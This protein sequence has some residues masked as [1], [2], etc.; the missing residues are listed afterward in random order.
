M[1]AFSE[2]AGP[3]LSVGAAELRALES[4][5]RLQL[6]AASGLPAERR[7]RLHNRLG[8]LLYGQVR[9][10]EA[11]AEY[12]AALRAWPTL[13]AAAHNRAIVRYRMGECVRYFELVSVLQFWGGF[14][15]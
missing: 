14:N 12:T 15:T 11:A 10:D 6:S 13:A 1:A 9:F 4:S 3:E 2:P 7:A 8:L 5:C